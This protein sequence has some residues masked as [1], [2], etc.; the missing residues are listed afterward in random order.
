MALESTAMDPSIDGMEVIRVRGTRV[1]CLRDIDIDIPLGKFVVVT[2]VSGS[3]K[4]SL[5]Y[6]TIHAEGQ[7][8]YLESLPAHTRQ[9]LPK[10]EKPDV[11]EIENIPPSIAVGQSEGVR[12]STTVAAASGVLDY[13][14]SWWARVATVTCGQ[15]GH[16]VNVGSPESIARELFGRAEGTKVTI[17]FVP[18]SFQLSSRADQSTN[19]TEKSADRKRNADGAVS[20]PSI[21]AID[22]HVWRESGFVRVQWRDRIYRLDNSDD[23]LKLPDR[24]LE[25]SGEPPRVLVDRLVTGSQTMS[26]WIEALETAFA[27]GEG[28]IEIQIGTAWEQR[29]Q[30]LTCA[31]CRTEYPVPTPAL[32]RESNPI[33]IC[34]ACAGTSRATSARRSGT[35]A[36]EEAG[37]PCPVCNG[38]RFSPLILSY[39]IAGASLADMLAKPVAEALQ[40]VEEN[41]AVARERGLAP[42]VQSISVRLR[43]L[44]SVGVGYLSLD[45]TSGSLSIGES[46]R[47]ALTNAFGSSLSGLLLVLDEPTAGL[48]PSETRT[49]L[50]ALRSLV[51]QGQSLLV[52]EHDPQVIAASDWVI[53]LGPGAGSQGGT[54]VFQGTPANLKQCTLSV[55]GRFLSRGTPS[56]SM[57]RTPRGSMSLTGAR[58]HNLAHVDVEFPL[59]VLVAV[60]GPS[61][62]G[63]SSLVFDCLAPAVQSVITRQLPTF[64]TWTGLGGADRFDDLVLVDGRLPARS[65]RSHPAT[66]LKILDLIR[67]LFAESLEARTRGLKPGDF[68]TNVAGGRCPTCEGTGF[69]MIDMQFLPDIRVHC[70][71]CEGRRYTDIILEVKYRGLD[72]AEVLD[73]SAREAFGFFRGQLRVLERIKPMLDVGLDYLPLGQPLATLSGGERQRLKMA[74][75]LSASGTRCLFLLDEPTTGLHP[76]DVKVLLTCFR[77]LLDA[78]HSIVV[79]EH[80][81]ELLSS[82]D[83]LIE[84]GPG[85]GPAGGRVVTT[86]TPA[87]IAMGGTLTADVLR[88]A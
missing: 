27:Y 34:G 73:L 20:E 11:D 51:E 81:P 53:D 69:Q 24:L 13:L 66:Y 68:S 64:P 39:R 72:V 47:I 17:G 5:V 60:V 45:R 84:L 77:N 21:D 9:W 44:V 22:W 7:R 55:T 46:Q 40:W 4:S 38:C 88:G 79:V 61:G 2:G 57:P 82:A 16:P 8:R 70:P 37:E 41:A 30:S 59:N 50:S 58:A 54:V 86:G 67:P 43:Y 49:L 80:D 65:S 18:K 74:R 1:N 62:A 78:G 56:F 19:P 12:E 23:L 29:N 87:A 63:K 15:C 48:H 36:V 25:P 33:A 71:D 85:A 26:R 52:V 42:V 10:F 32:F 31:Q 35:D 6:D 14:R 76:L 3:G 75:H 83:Y 28:S